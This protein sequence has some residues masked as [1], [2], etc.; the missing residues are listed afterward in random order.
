[1][2]LNF[3]QE[4]EAELMDIVDENDVP[5][6]T[7]M[8]PDIYRDLPLHRIVH[9]MLFDA[10][11]RFIL[12]L[13]SAKKAYKPLHWVTAVSGHPR[14][15]ETYEQAAHRE[16]EEELGASLVFLNFRRLFYIDAERPALRRF[17]GVLEAQF[18][19]I[20][21]L[22]ADEVESV[23]TVKREELQ[24]MLQDPT[25]KFHPELRA[26]LVELYGFV[27]K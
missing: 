21:T 14:A 9:G 1:M 23:K 12:Q 26:I 25:E 16:G 13:R 24:G 2:G 5:I 19:G 3:Q 11:G 7:A 6:G 10:S 15:G 22:N 27:V 4:H 8:R 17:L 20:F 18:D